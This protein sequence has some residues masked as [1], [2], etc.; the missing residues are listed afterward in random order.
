MCDHVLVF[1]CLFLFCAAICIA[2]GLIDPQNIN[3]VYISF[4]PH[5]SQL[6]GKNVKMNPEIDTVMLMDG[7][8]VPLSIC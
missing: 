6:A 7:L 3:N 8:F 2:I 4:L 1:I 5:M